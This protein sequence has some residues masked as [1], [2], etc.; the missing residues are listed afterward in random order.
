LIA[1]QPINAFLDIGSLAQPATA[2]RRSAAIKHPAQVIQGAFERVALAQPGRVFVGG[3][4][5]V[6]P[7]LHPR[8]VKQ[9]RTARQGQA[10]QREE[11]P[12]KWRQDRIQAPGE[13]VKTVDVSQ[14]VGQQR[15]KVTT[16]QQPPID[17]QH[18]ADPAHLQPLVIIAHLPEV[19]SFERWCI[20]R[21][22]SLLKCS[23]HLLKALDL[24]AAW[25]EPD[26]Q[27]V[28]FPAGDNHPSHEEKHMRGNID[29]DQEVRQSLLR[30]HKRMPVRSIR[31]R[32]S[33]DQ[34]IQ[35][36]HKSFSRPNKEGT[37]A[38]MNLC[39]DPVMIA[40]PYT[41]HPFNTPCKQKQGNP[42]DACLLVL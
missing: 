15:G 2:F 1:V 10:K 5:P 14:L 24:S 12:A 11:A 17:H 29:R 23:K 19:R 13:Q 22:L 4:H 40:D 18:H 27:F 21:R 28:S 34:G 32:E 38:V 30:Q 37:G 16:H 39:K 3:K 42:H 26:P 35:H 20:G 9:D 25:L 31:L 36:L 33:R 41:S 8:Q 7:V 6:S